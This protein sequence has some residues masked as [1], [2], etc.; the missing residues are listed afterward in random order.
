MKEKSRFM[1]EKRKAKPLIQVSVNQSRIEINPT[2]LR[3]VAERI[4]NALGYTEVE[5]SILIVDDEEMARLNLEYREVD[6]TTDVLSF[7][8]WEGEFGDVCDE[9]LG[10]I[11]IS[12]PTAQAMSE[13]HHS[14]LDRVMDLL[15]VHGVLHLVGLDHEAGEEEA[16]RMQ[17]KTLELLG[18]LGHSAKSFDW[19]A[20]KAE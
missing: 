20:L 2:R 19:Y 7:P 3:D 1:R 18:L 5:L 11:V 15:L 14:T 6:S 8:M 9:M 4:L 12:A 13:Q 16:R 17:E 10:D